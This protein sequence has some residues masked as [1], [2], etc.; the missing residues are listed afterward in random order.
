[1]KKLVLVFVFGLGTM[2]LPFIAFLAIL[3]VAGTAIACAPNGGGPLSASAPVPVAARGW[4]SIT[5]AACPVLPAT[6]IAAV[7]M[8]ESGF[9]PDAYADDKNGGTWG[10]FQ[11]NA[12]IW[13]NAYGAPWDADLNSNGVWDVKDPEI[14][15]AVA[16]KYLCGRLAG[17]ERIRA[18]HPDWASTRELSELDDL[19]IA[20]NA[21][22]GRLES[23]PDIPAITSRFVVNVRERMAT[24]ATAD[25]VV[26]PTVV[27]STPGSGVGS[28]GPFAGPAGATDLAASC[29]AG[30][31]P[32]P[33][34]SSS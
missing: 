10:L 23:Y 28:I 33:S 22:E 19:V 9:R 31:S 14:H 15:A 1:M 4:V 32:V 13:R 8:Q 20:H 34:A 18:A 21:G 29:A 25:V 30:P 26:A 5:Q 27:P 6:F 17:V 16:G 11:L 24:W 2:S 7:M 3:G 12:S